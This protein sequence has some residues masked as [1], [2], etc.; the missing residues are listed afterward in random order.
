[1]R[2]EVTS[3]LGIAFNSTLV[4]L[5]ISIFLMFFIHS[6]QARQ[7]GTILAIETFCREHLIDRFRIYQENDTDDAKTYTLKPV[8]D[9]EE[10]TEV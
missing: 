7:E 6:L 1:M 5:F 3:A 4:A 9:G 10:T 2:C 8:D